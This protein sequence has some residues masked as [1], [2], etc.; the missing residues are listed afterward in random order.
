MKQHTNHM[1]YAEVRQ[2]LQIHMAT[3]L[4]DIGRRINLGVVGD[5]TPIYNFGICEDIREYV[6]FE[7]FMDTI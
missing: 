1:A 3:L 2:D 7:R 4:N 5:M 6:K